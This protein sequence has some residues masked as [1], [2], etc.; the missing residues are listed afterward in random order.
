MAV[1]LINKNRQMLIGK[2]IP[3]DIEDRFFEIMY[4][5]PI[6][7]K[8]IDFKSTILDINIYR[9]KCEIEFNGSALMREMFE[10]G[11]LKEEYEEIKDDY[12]SYIKH[13]LGL[14]DRTPRVVGKKIDEL[15]KKIRTEL[16]SVKYIDIEVN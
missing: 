15:E 9:I 11:S 8:V 7:E 13:C 2:S 5:D 1:M 12:E 3:Q 16:P 10:Q 14:I 4:A 6:V